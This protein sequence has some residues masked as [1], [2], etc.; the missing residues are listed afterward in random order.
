VI[1]VKGAWASASDSTTPL[2]EGGSV[3]NN[4]YTNEY[5]GL[6]LPVPAD[7]HEKYKG[8]P[9]SDSGYYSLVQLVPAE[10]FQ[11]PAK[12]S[13]LVTA[14]DLFFSLVPASD[15]AALVSYT[16]DKLNAIY[17]VERAP[18]MATIANHTF[19][20][21]DYVAPEADLHWYMLATE[22]RC[23]AVQFIFTSRDTQLLEKLLGEVSKITL[24]E[25]ADPTQGTGGGAAPVCIKD[26]AT[27]ENMVSRVEPLP[28]EHRF[29]PVPVRIIIGKDG[30]VEHI[31]FLSAFPDQAKAITDA[32][33]QWKFKPH[34]QNG[35]AARVETGIMFGVKPRGK[36]A[37][38]AQPKSSITN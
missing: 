27:P 12:G 30:S 24:P 31:H 23:H 5:F 8:P 15:A 26:Y 9:P 14:Q 6:S 35:E 28:T 16:R 11:G 19:V 32:V 4:V 2:P 13:V 37:A 33:M 34:V 10:S 17:K 21:F 7:F 20:R 22:I 36:P 1:L 38:A 25:Q 18:A 29:N 3:A